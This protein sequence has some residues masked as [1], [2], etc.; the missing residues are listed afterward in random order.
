MTVTKGYGEIF[1]MIAQGRSLT[2][3]LEA[4]ID[5]L[6]Q[7]LDQKIVCIHLLDDSASDFGIAVYSHHVKEP[8]ESELLL[9]RDVAH[10]DFA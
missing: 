7:R 8:S 2:A 3:I 6:E 4:L 5:I 1:E 10:P 9:Q